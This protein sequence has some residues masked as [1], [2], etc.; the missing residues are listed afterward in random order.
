MRAFARFTVSRRSI[1]QTVNV[2][3]PEE[4]GGENLTNQIVPNNFPEQAVR[5][6]SRR[7]PFDIGRSYW[8]S[9]RLHRSHLGFH[10]RISS[11]MRIFNHGRPW[12]GKNQAPPTHLT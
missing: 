3:Q 11:L 9:C 8:R 12:A 5:S 6:R 1:A 2:G 7:L 4:A 10:F